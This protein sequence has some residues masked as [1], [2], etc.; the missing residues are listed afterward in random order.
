MKNI[1][2]ENLLRFG[3]KNLSESDKN[4]LMEQTAISSV[5]INK[6]PDVIAMGKACAAAGKGKL[7][8]NQLV[9][10]AG[11]Q[12]Y[13]RLDKKAENTN[14]GSGSVTSS[15]LSFSVYCIAKSKFGCPVPR[16][17]AGVF[18]AANG[19]VEGEQTPSVI[20][21]NDNFLNLPTDDTS[22][23]WKNFDSATWDAFATSTFVQYVNNI[24]RNAKYLG[25]LSRSI[26]SNADLWKQSKKP[27][28]GMASVL[29]KIVDA[30]VVA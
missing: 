24:I 26:I 1:L 27:A 4:K 21:L 25:M 7:P 29:Q 6:H 22:I 10:Y 14:A 18:V 20:T 11:T 30:V 23:G 3:V 28:S 13:C 9:E 16:Y 19:A 17:I 5:L 8:Y 15:R 12:L 2:A